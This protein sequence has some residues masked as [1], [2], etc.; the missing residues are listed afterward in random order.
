[1]ADTRVGMLVVHG[2][3]EQD[4]GRT[5]E[6]LVA[7]IRAAL[8]DHGVQ[9][10]VTSDDGKVVIDAG[11]RELRLYEVHWADVLQKRGAE[12]AF[13]TGWMAEAAWFPWLN[14]RGA[15][16]QGGAMSALKTLLW[17]AL[18]VPATL[19]LW[20]GYRGAA[21]IAAVIGLAPGLFSGRR[22]D[23]DEADRLLDRLRRR[24]FV[25]DALDRSLGDV[26]TYVDSA[27]G[28]LPRDSR[29]SGAADD[30]LGRFYDRLER[31][32]ADGCDE[33]QVV[34]HS[35]GSVVAFH[36]ITG[37]RLQ[38]GEAGEGSIDPLAKLTR[39]YTIG[40]PLGK[41]R[42]LWP[43]LVVDRL[44]GPYTPGGAGLPTRV[45]ELPPEPAFAWRNYRNL[46]DPVAGRLGG[47]GYWSPDTTRLFEGG[48]IR[49][50]IV[51]DRNRR[52]LGDLLGGVFGGDLAPRRRWL[53][54]AWGVALSAFEVLAV[55]IVV[56][57]LLALGL[58]LLLVA[59]L[60]VPG[61]VASGLD[62][63]GLGGLSDFVDSWGWLVY[64]VAALGAYAAASY[65][66][67]ARE[68]ARIWVTPPPGRGL[69]IRRR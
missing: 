11:E 26:V 1:M 35:L 6:R 52:F 65:R 14:W 42:Y 47:F 10:T 7:G 44:L 15:L 53:R 20:L 16:T 3:G 8:D 31:A 59:G 50:H 68:H 69:P 62:D 36:A 4:P 39:L 56:L 25:D 46:L 13:E 5:A 21:L 45:D 9:H 18:L 30:I 48:L 22:E 55:S 24:T 51:Y 28:A 64:V 67:A 58:A 40:S 41:I 33:I 17:T 2:M 66:R 27:G 34:A 38:P 12:G 23:E 32:L 29:L 61:W 54:S 63:V 49:S 19:A 60:W 43:R 57:V 37:Y